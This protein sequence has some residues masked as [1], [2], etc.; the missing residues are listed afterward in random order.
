MVRTTYLLV[1]QWPA[2]RLGTAAVMVWIA[3]RLLRSASEMALGHPGCVFL[4]GRVEQLG[5]PVLKS[6]GPVGE[7]LAKRF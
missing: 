6:F 1:E 5:D 4:S 2:I 7:R 3:M